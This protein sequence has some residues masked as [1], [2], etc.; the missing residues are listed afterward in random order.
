MAKRTSFFDW[1]LFFTRE[2]MGAVVAVLSVALLLVLC[3]SGMKIS[4]IWSGL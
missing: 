1:R 4:G 2:V 3:Y